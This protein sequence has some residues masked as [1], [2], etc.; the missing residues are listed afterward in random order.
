MTF[1]KIQGEYDHVGKM[2]WLY[3]LEKKDDSN[4]TAFHVEFSMAD[5]NEIWNDESCICTFLVSKIN[6]VKIRS[7]LARAV[8]QGFAKR[9][10]LR[11]DL[12]LRKPEDDSFAHT[13]LETR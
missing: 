1:H 4:F 11:V 3:K 8:W 12:S 6:Q 9:M 2:T 5:A 13:Q 10:N 7:S